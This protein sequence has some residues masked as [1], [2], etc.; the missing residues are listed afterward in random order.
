M[1]FEWNPQTIQWYE[2]ANTYSGF[3]RNL[4]GLI[5]PMLRGYS[6]LCDLGCGLGLLDLELS[7]SISEITCVDINEVAL[8]ALQKGIADRQVS[9][10]EPRLMDCGELEG[11]WDVICISF[12]G[13]KEFE[14][15][16][17]HCRKLIAVVGRRQQTELY[18]DKYRKYLKNSAEKVEEV[19]SRKGMDYVLTEAAFEFGQPFHSR[20]DAENFVRTHCP[21]IT[22]EDLRSFLDGA[23]RETGDSRFPL[24]I[25]RLKSLG[26][27]EIKG[28]L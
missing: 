7:P 21:A 2:D 23:L 28:C 17:P 11:E 14:N 4:A 25:P 24:V 18:P 19:L 16:L 22:P 12:F 13:S 3:F 8:A 20:A 15:F 9:N 1:N 27:F 6:T 5:S 10:L 26:V